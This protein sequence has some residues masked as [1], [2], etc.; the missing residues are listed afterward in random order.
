MTVLI[1]DT[2][3]LINAV[4]IPVALGL[5]LWVAVGGARVGER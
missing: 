5:L 2:I 1:A 3:L 4:S